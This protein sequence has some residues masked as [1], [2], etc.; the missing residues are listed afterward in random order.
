[1][2]R[3]FYIAFYYRQHLEE[4]F[5]TWFVAATFAKQC[6]AEGGQII[7]SRELSVKGRAQLSTEISLL[8]ALPR[9]TTH[10]DVQPKGNAQSRS[11][12]DLDLPAELSVRIA[13]GTKTPEAGAALRFRFR[14]A[15]ENHALTG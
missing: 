2:S 4:E 3:P 5:S 15:G 7:A 9:W 14:A 1:M 10:L 8:I 12:P 13:P 6:L 11:A